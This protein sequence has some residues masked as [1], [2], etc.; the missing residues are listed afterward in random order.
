MQALKSL[1]HDLTVFLVKYVTSI[2]SNSESISLLS[3]FKFTASLFTLFTSY[4]TEA[5]H[6]IALLI[7]SIKLR[8]VDTKFLATSFSSSILLQW[9]IAT[10]FSCSLFSYFT[11]SCWTSFCFWASSCCYLWIEVILLSNFVNK[12]ES[13]E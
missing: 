3:F 6:F 4:S 1:F 8:L 11:F 10:L 7:S 13:S 9:S 2:L 5:K 12:W